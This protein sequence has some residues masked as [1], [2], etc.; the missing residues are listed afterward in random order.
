MYNTHEN[1]MLK[2]KKK[3][4]QKSYVVL[5]HLYAIFRKDKLMERES[6]EEW[7]PGAEGRGDWKGKFPYEMMKY[8]ETRQR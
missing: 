6:R 5:Y 4:T 7:L 2:E 8:F 1:I 3:Q